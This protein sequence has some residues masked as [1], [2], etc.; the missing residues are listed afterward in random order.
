MSGAQ[1]QCLVCLMN[2][3]SLS[4]CFHQISKH[5]HITRLCK[6]Y[7]TKIIVFASKYSFSTS[8]YEYLRLMAQNV[9]VY[10]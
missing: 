2:D 6:L 9:R 5:D 3:P 8:T 7:K 1:R 4:F 10:C